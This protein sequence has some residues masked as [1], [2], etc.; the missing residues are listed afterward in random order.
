MDNYYQA[1]PPKSKMINFIAFLLSIV[2]SGVGMYSL[3]SSYS[4]N[5]ENHEEFKDK[6]KK[7]GF[8]LLGITAFLYV[9]MY[10]TR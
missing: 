5:C 6:S 8:I 10:F 1:P 4:L 2:I 3:I 9:L 7:G